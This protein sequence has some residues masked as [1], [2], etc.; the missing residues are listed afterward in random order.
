[1]PYKSKVR[2]LCRYCGKPIAKSTV[3]VYVERT[4]LPYHRDSAWSRYV[5]AEQRPTSIEE[6][7]KLISAAEDIISV[8]YWS[9]AIERFNVWDRESYVDKHFCSTKCA[10]LFGDLMAEA[11]P[12]KG[13]STWVKAQQQQRAE[14]E[15]T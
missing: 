1:M 8:R 15:H 14:A 9:S 10:A 6:C 5:Y 4:P 12:T 2:P 11:Y 13:T 3:T 7:R